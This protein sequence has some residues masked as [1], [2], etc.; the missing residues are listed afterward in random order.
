MRSTWANFRAPRSVG[1][2]CSRRFSKHW[3]V[4]ITVNLRGLTWVAKR[5]SSKA[6]DRKA[7]VEV[8]QRQMYLKF[9]LEHIPWKWLQISRASPEV[10][11]QVDIKIELETQWFSTASNIIIVDTKITANHEYFVNYI[12]GLIQG[13]WVTISMKL[14]HGVTMTISSPFSWTLNYPADIS[15]DIV[16]ICV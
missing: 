16:G 4:W 11:S 12:Q 5:L 3:L 13:S 8:Q 14:F 6:A 9:Q 7:R 1:S 15:I 2:C 10:T